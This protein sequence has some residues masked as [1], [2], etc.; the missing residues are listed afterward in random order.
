ME[1]INRI[2]KRYNPIKKINNFIE[3]SIN[4]ISTAVLIVETLY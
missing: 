2:I 3:V 4:L 1:M